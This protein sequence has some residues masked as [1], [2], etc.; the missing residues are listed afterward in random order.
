MFEEERREF[1]IFFNYF[2]KKF[3]EEIGLLPGIYE[4]DDFEIDMVMG[5][6][7]EEFYGV[8][9]MQYVPVDESTLEEG[10]RL[11]E[12]DEIADLEEDKKD[13]GGKDDGDEDED[14]EEYDEDEDD[15]D[16]LMEM[17]LYDFVKTSE[18]NP[19]IDGQPYFQIVLN[20]P[21]DDE[22]EEGEEGKNTDSEVKTEPKT[23]PKPELKLLIYAQPLEE[24]YEGD[25]QDLPG[26]KVELT[27]AVMIKGND[28]STKV[29]FLADPDFV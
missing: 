24:P 9:I 14:D 13:E 17:I 4:D 10:D 19:S 29:V 8:R 1:E 5:Q 26:E 11:D 6:D 12:I 16:E 23:E 27:G 7:S 18:E 3:K 25:F 22:E 20:A 2:E 21:G 15:E 28:P